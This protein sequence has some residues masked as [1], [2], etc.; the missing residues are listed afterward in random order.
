MHRVE[1]ALVDE[2]AD[3]GAGFARVADDD[4][5]VDLFELRD[6]LVVDA[7]V[8]DEAAEGGAA[9]ACGAHGGEGDGAEGE[10]EVGGGGDDGCVVAAEFEDGSGEAGG[11]AWGDGAAHCGAAGGGDEWD[12]WGVDEL[13][14]Y[15]CVADEEGGEA[16]GTL[17]N[18]FGRS[19]EDGLRGE[20]G[21]RSFFAGLPD[22]G[23]AADEGERG[24]PA[25]DG[26]GEVEGGDDAD[27]AERMPGLH[28]AVLGA[29]GGDG[30]AGEL[31]REAGGE[32]ADVD[33]LLDFA[34]AFGEDLAGFDG[35]EAAER[36]DVGAEFFAEEADEFAAF[37]CGDVAPLEEG[38]VG[39]GDGFG[40]VGCGDGGEV[41]DD[42]AG[43]GRANGETATGVGGVGHA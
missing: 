34:E 22:D 20:C 33:H 15:G 9:L 31:A 32:G 3:E 38:G 1:G 8:D 13:L 16:L 10:V 7:V 11:E 41:G 37:G 29:L 23:V 40:C 17:P 21:E 2:W 19:L 24:V 27:D 42:F 30:E 5:G 43:D 26:D 4:G 6:E 39:L 25:P 18:F 35:D 28:H 14:A 12:E 36:F